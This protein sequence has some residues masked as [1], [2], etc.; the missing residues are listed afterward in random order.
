MGRKMLV[1]AT[2]NI[3]SVGSISLWVCTK[4]QQTKYYGR[5]YVDF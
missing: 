3:M 1:A 2:L 4:E 5:S